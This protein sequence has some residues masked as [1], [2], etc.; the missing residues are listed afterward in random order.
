LI[1]QTVGAN[2]TGDD[3]LTAWNIRIKKL[4]FCQHYTGEGHKS[5]EQLQNREKDISLT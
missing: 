5:E 3:W 1:E 4:R 2:G